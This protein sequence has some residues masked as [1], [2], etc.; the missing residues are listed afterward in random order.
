MSIT[1]PTWKKT[2]P[3]DPE[4]THN[5]YCPITPLASIAGISVSRARVL[6]RLLIWT[7][8]LRHPF[9]ALSCLMTIAGVA[10]MLPAPRP[11]QTS[12][13]LRASM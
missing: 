4:D 12:R 9:G 3:D 1:H 13:R 2:K 6:D 10:V 5:G 11:A 8:L 7:G